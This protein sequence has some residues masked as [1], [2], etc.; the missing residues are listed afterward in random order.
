VPSLRHCYRQVELGVSAAN[1]DDLPIVFAGM[2]RVRIDSSSTRDTRDPL[3]VA[4][5]GCSLVVHLC[6]DLSLRLGRD[7]T[8]RSRT[9]TRQAASSL[10]DRVVVAPY[11]R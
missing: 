3:L 2:T 9:P 11:D 4:P 7:Q 8:H 10:L 6:H 5:C 1:L